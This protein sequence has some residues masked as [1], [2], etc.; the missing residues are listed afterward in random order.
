MEIPE[1]IQLKE[2]IQQMEHNM[3]TLKWDYERGQIN[4]FKKKLYEDMLQEKSK[5]LT[6]IQEFST[7]SE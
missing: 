2:Q 4:P 5:L 1:I 6:Q 7:I 3:L